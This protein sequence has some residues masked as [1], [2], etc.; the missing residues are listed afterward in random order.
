[1]NEIMRMIP[2][3]ITTMI[4]LLY[5][6]NFIVI[7]LIRICT[8]YYCQENMKYFIDLLI[9]FRRVILDSI[10]ESKKQKK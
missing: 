7:N 2:D 10:A 9:P 4:L 6:F 5:C 8:Y 1:M 3:W